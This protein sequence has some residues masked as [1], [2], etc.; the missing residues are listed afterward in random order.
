MFS[1][2]GSISYYYY[3]NEDRD[4]ECVNQPQ[5]MC[6]FKFKNPGYVTAGMYTTLLHTYIL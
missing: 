3:Q 4:G 6:K 2:Y 1:Y 5:V